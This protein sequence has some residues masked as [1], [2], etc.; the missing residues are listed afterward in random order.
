MQFGDILGE[1][2]IFIL[3]DL[4]VFFFIIFVWSSTDGS[5]VLAA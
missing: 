1:A 4:Q 3:I 2:V 5:S